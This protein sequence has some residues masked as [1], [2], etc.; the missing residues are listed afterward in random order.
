MLGAL[1]AVIESNAVGEAELVGVSF[2]ISL[3]D[4]A[5]DMLTGL[6][7]KGGLVH[8]KITEFIGTQ[9]VI[10]FEALVVTMFG[11]HS[12]NGAGRLQEENIAVRIEVAIG[13]DG[14]ESAPPW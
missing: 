5:G 13:L 4:L 2:H 14:G 7:A 8:G 11:P 12:A 10:R 9:H 3:D 1:H 6:H